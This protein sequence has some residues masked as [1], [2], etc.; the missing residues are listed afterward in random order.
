MTRKLSV[1][2]EYL[3]WPFDHRY[4]ESEARCQTLYTIYE[5]N[6]SIYIY[7]EMHPRQWA[8]VCEPH[9]TRLV[10]RFES[11]PSNDYWIATQNTNIVKREKKRR[12]RCLNSWSK[13]ETW[14]ETRICVPTHINYQWHV[15]TM[16]WRRLS[17]Q[18]HHGRTKL[19]FDAPF[20][21]MVTMDSHWE[22]FETLTMTK[23]KQNVSDSIAATWSSLTLSELVEQ[24]P[25]SILLRKRGGI[26]AG[27]S[28]HDPV[29]QLMRYVPIIS[30]QEMF[31]IWNFVCVVC[32]CCSL[33][34]DH[35]PV[36]P[37]EIIIK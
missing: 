14:N 33:Y 19:R 21:S 7:I 30:R 34:F 1:V 3:L 25:N 11:N 28:R 26:P 12:K 17:R 18:C 10:N 2:W 15:L 35:S 32:C 22:E 36:S 23:P 6:V 24:I 4:R 13:L 8:A 9:R 29:L 37:T 27:C 16:L 31:S 5:Y 20:S